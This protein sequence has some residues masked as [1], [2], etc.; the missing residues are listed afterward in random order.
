[1]S[2]QTGAGRPRVDMTEAI[3]A[4]SRSDVFV[5]GLSQA[6]GGPVGEHAVPARWKGRFWSASRVILALLLLTLVFSFVQKS[7]CRSGAWADNLQYT[8]FCYTDVLALYG[9]EGL[10]D[11]QVPY[12]D[13][14]VEYPVLTGA[15]MGLIGLPVHAYGV[16]HPG[17][18]QYQAFYDITALALFACAIA[19]VLMLLSI[20]K[21]RPWD[22]AMFALSP[23]LLVTATVNWD[24]LAI[25]LAV[26]GIWAWSKRH[27]VVAGLFIGLGAAAKLW[28]GFLLVP[29]VGLALRSLI[30]TRLLAAAKERAVAVPIPPTPSQ[31]VRGW[32]AVGWHTVRGWLA[33]AW[34]RVKVDWA[35]VKAAW[36]WVKV[37]WYWVTGF[38][39]TTADYLWAGITAVLAVAAI[40]VPVMITHFDNW[41]RFIGLN[42][43]RGV[44]WG[45]F[46]YVGRW[47][48]GLFWSGGAGDRGL[49]QWLSDSLGDPND[50]LL[51]TVYQGLFVLGCAGVIAL[52]ILAKREPRFT[53]LGFI[54]VAIFLLTSKVWSQQFTLWLLPLVVLARPRWWAFLAWQIC[55]LCYFF[56]FYG[57]LLGAS[58]KGVIPEGTFILAATMRWVSVAVLVVFVVREILNP[59]LDVVR[60]TAVV[61]GWRLV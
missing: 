10:A 41:H 24:L 36:T 30:G 52:A 19:T 53:Q 7:P 48:D 2:T 60:S 32:L 11:G 54:V 38:C 3:D 35:W 15:F 43:E 18:N 17:F 22:V 23:V 49:F 9:A 50:R 5:G 37:G 13:H 47:A 16:K 56:A 28:P 51:N 14:D 21:R 40:N 6:V 31:P 27:P 46:W 12:V 8:K 4:P 59:K 61:P 58:G 45:T 34:T 20:R 57:E 44:D 33:A 26:A 55:E 29:L 42:T 1:M 25:V 39:R